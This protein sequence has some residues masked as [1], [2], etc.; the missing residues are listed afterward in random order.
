[1]LSLRA[2]VDGPGHAGREGIVTG[3]RLETRPANKADVAAVF[4]LV[5]EFATSFT[6]ERASFERS[7]RRVLSDEHACMLVADG[8][9]RIVGYLLGFVHPAFHAN[10][11]VAWV[12]EIAVTAELRRSGIG[13]RLMAAF[14]R[15]AASRDARLMALATRRAAMFYSALGYDESAAYFRKL[16][17]RPCSCERRNRR[18]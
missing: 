8:G 3:D 16:R 2:T 11:V 14:E 9:E 13:T 10:G 15:W 1:M 6:P 4:P 17:D 7:F 5:V 12:E 18:P